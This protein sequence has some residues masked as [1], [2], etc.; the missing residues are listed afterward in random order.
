MKIFALVNA[1]VEH[2]SILGLYTS[3]EMAEKDMEF[4]AAHEQATVCGDDTYQER[5]TKV[6]EI[7]YNQTRHR[8]DDKPWP[9]WTD[10]DPTIHWAGDHILIEEYE[11]KDRS[12]QDK[13]DAVN[14]WQ[15]NSQVH[16]LTCGTDSTHPPLVPQWRYYHRDIGLV[17]THPDCNYA[18]NFV[19]EIIYASYFSNRP[20]TS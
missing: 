2:H 18:E 20:Q 5:W 19:P 12:Y 7:W 10:F 1:G 8:Y 6:G 14:A 17:C 4:V 9:E 15:T 3:K 13:I 11:A 16:P